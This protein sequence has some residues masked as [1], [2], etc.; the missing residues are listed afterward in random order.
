ME[1][2]L[3]PGFQEKR[4]AFCSRGATPS[5]GACACGPRTWGGSIPAP[6]VSLPSSTVS[7]PSPTV[8]LPS[9]TVS[10]PSPGGCSFSGPV[11]DLWD[12]LRS[13]GIS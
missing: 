12:E 7:L 10:L 1:G 8:S 4:K 11:T 9:P 5:P 3:S 13:L 6:T 2:P